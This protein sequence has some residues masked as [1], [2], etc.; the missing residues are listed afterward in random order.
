MI[1][2]KWGILI[3]NIFK[4][5]IQRFLFLFFGYKSIIEMSSIL[6]SS[7]FK[8][9]GILTFSLIFKPDKF[10]EVLSSLCFNFNNSYLSYWLVNKA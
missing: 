7:S 8:F 9:L 1:Y 6:S 2:Y 3:S 5:Y 4:Y 10:L